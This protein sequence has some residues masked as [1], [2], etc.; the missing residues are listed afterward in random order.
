MLSFLSAL[1]HLG[2]M[3]T[4][5]LILCALSTV[6]SNAQPMHADVEY[7]VIYGNDNRRIHTELD[8][9]FDADL[10]KVSDATLA[11]IPN[12]RI[13]SSADDVISI[14]TKDLRS[15]LNYCP[16]ERFTESPSVSSCS[17]FLVA[18]DLI[19][20]AGHCVKDKYDCKK[21]TWV[22]DYNDGGEFIAPSGSVSFQKSKS[23]SCA[24]LVSWSNNP[25]LDF[26]LI[27]LNR[28]VDDRKPLPIR[29]VGKVAINEELALAGHP[30]GLPKVISDR[31]TI[32]DNSLTYTFK[33]NADAFSGNS[34]SPIYGRDSKMVEGILVRG[35][36]DFELNLDLICQRPKKCRD[37]ECRG[38]VVQRTSV[39][40]LKY[41]PKI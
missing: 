33:T 6:S 24:E 40:P 21:Q 27:R 9:E 19:L 39:L 12:W 14:K 34:G 37:D 1:W 8:T 13:D 32:R 18:P 29:R 11:Q 30:L 23:Y 35:E 10:I 41:I 25:R 38:E 7:K 20:T 22:L 31:I 3:K 16:D 4:L 5:F 36:D 26:A 2:G 15:G 28:K 17:A